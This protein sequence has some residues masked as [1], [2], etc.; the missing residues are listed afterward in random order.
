M[1]PGKDGIWA[2][3]TRN[4]TIDSEH[5]PIPQMGKLNPLFP[6]Q[7]CSN[8]IIT[9]RVKQKGLTPEKTIHPTLKLHVKNTQ[10]LHYQY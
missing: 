9:A 7:N 2:G 5:A 10:S 4:E 6:E 8:A 1:L 3:P